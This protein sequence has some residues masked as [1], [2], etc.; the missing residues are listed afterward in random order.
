MENVKRSCILILSIALLFGLLSACG[1]PEESVGQTEQESKSSS[2][3]A[4]EATMAPTQAPTEPQPELATAPDPDF[5]LNTGS[6]SIIGEYRV[7]CFNG[8]PTEAVQHYVSV[9]QDQYAMTLVES[10]SDGSTLGWYLQRGSNENADVDVSINCTGGINWEL[11]ISFGSDVELI[12]AQTWDEPIVPTISGPTLPSPDAFFNNQLARN[13][14][15]YS[16]KNERYAISFKADIDNGTLAMQEY[17]FLLFDGKYNLEL[18][19]EEEDTVQTLKTFRYVFTYTGGEDVPDTVDDYNKIQGDLLV[20]IQRNGKTET[21]L[22]TLYFQ[23]N[24]YAFID[25]GD[26]TSYSLVDCSGNQSNTDSDDL[27]GTDTARQ[28]CNICRGTGECKTC[29]GDGYLW[30]SASDK[31]DRN[32]YKC[33]PNYGDCPYCNGTG[34]RD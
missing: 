9:L 30:S 2:I 4:T 18:S 6:D 33:H 19:F 5:Y 16:E 27:G 22:M 20:Y 26:R 8:N 34:W 31:E 14:D 29:N 1:Q 13:E 7:Y 11:W 28:E 32:C 17:V 3:A 12:A 25:F 10:Y 21:V 15:F 23:P 24:V